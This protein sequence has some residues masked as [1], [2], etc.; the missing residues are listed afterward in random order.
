MFQGRVEVQQLDLAD[1][2]SVQRLAEQL[3]SESRIDVLILNAG[4]M[5]CPQTYTEDNFEL[6]IGTNHFGHFE[7]TR[8]LLDKLQKQVRILQKS[9]S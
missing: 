6:Q 1:L 5:A 3:N 2:R 8:L 9:C 7:L 4:V